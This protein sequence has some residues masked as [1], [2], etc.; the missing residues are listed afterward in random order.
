M[1]IGHVLRRL[2]QAQGWSQ[3]A[4]ATQ[5]GMSQSNYSNIE[6]NK[7]EVNQAQIIQFA[8]IFQTT[9]FL[10]IQAAIK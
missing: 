4:V 5:A 9:P 3:E 2:R 8:D 1:K 7:Q 6:S 10:L